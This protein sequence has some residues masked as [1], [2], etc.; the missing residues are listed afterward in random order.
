MTI[1]FKSVPATFI[2]IPRTGT[3]SLKTWVIANI[4]DHEIINDAGNRNQMAHVFSKDLTQ[5]WSN[6]GTTFTF[7]RNPFDRLVSIFHHIGQDAET[8]L[9]DRKAGMQRYGLTVQSIEEDIKILSIYK[10]GFEQWIMNAQF[11]NTN[12]RLLNSLYNIREENQLYWLSNQLPDI[13]IKLENIDT[14]FK[15]VQALLGCDAPF[16]HVNSS[17]HQHYREY[18]TDNTRNIVSEWYREE[19]ELFKYEF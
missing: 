18:Y 8:N 12:S 17:Q 3:T 15:Q 9:R 2:N 19:L 7:I 1:H 13:V 4:K 14:E 5:Y 10:R 11:K 6:P 16:V